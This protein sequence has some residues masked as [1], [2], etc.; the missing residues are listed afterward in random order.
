MR[1]IDFD[2]A[3]AYMCNARFMEVLWPGVLMICAS[4]NEKTAPRLD[5]LS[6]LMSRM[7]LEPASPQ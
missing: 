7:A 3:L 5:L 4:M 6:H 1:G 2:I